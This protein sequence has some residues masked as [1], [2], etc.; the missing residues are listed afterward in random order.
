MNYKSIYYAKADDVFFCNVDETE[1]MKECA[2]YAHPEEFPG[3]VMYAE[4]EDVD[5]ALYILGVP[6][7]LD[8]ANLDEIIEAAG[9]DAAG[10]EFVEIE[11]YPNE[12]FSSPYRAIYHKN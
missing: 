11:F 5:D 4:V 2:Y 3:K 7:D 9:Y 6:G 1:L 8:T 10:I 12:E